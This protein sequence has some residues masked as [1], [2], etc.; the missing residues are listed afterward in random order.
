MP[1][2]TLASMKLGDILMC[3]SQGTGT[4]KVISLGENL[5]TGRSYSNYI[6][7]AI[8][9]DE[10]PNAKLVESHG[11][12]IT[13]A[14][15]NSAATVFRLNHTLEDADLLSVTAAAVAR[16]L[17]REHGNNEAFGQYSRIKATF[18]ICRTRG[19]SSSTKERVSGLARGDYS[20]ELFCSMFVV[21]CYQVAIKR[22]EQV[23]KVLPLDVDAEAMQPSFLVQYLKQNSQHWE[24]VGDFTP[25]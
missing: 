15:P 23:L 4:H 25:G 18:S 8:I 10:N 9:T 12:G 22:L 1:D 3:K 19:S 2:V 24:E 14:V 11:E 20:G 6:H 5:G 7:A 21:I 16:E 17:M 13:E